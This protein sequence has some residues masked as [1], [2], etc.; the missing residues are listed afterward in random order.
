MNSSRTQKHLDTLS[1]GMSVICLIHCLAV[2]LF[3]LL[4]MAVPSLLMSEELFHEMMLFAVVPLSSVAFFLGC[5]KHR[6]L[7]VLAYGLSG[8]ATLIFAALWMHDLGGHDA[9]TAMTLV[10]TSLMVIAHLKNYRLCRR[11]ECQH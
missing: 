10:G 6:N 3:L 2:P 5:R 8:L 4:G 11:C 9:E 1:I 7:S